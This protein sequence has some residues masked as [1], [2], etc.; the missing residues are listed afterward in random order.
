VAHA[1]YRLQAL[2]GHDSAGLAGLREQMRRSSRPSAAAVD[3]LLRGYAAAAEWHQSAMQFLLTARWI[4][5]DEAP[6]SI[7]DLMAASWRGLADSVE[8]PLI[9]ARLFGYPQAIPRY[10][11]PAAL[12][13]RVIAAENWAAEQWLERHGRTA[14]LET[15]QLMDTDL[16]DNASIESGGET[17]RLT[18]VRRQ[19]AEATNGFLE[20]RDAILV[21]PGYMPLLALGA[22]VHEWQHLAFERL[23]RDGLRVRDGVLVLPASD[24]FVAEGLAEWRTGELLAP[25]AEQFPLLALGEVEKRCR[26]S[27]ANGTEQHVLGAALVRALVAAVPDSRRRMTLLLAGADDPQAI[28]QAPELRRAWARFG[29]PDLVI[30][31]PSRRMLIPETRFTL[32]DR[33]PDIVASRILVPAGS[34]R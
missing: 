15:V 24:P 5:G 9:R 31:A 27:I 29:G 4:T 8:A 28:V 14:L 34:D 23:R 25:L 11:V 19:S 21:D 32:E 26:L 13:D 17:F 2:A 22:V 18:S 10:G 6:R 3:L 20:P 16:G 7:A 30:P 12:F 1:S 33:F